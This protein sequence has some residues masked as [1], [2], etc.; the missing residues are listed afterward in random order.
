M[1]VVGLEFATRL[2]MVG[3]GPLLLLTGRLGAA[4]DQLL[5][6]EVPAVRLRLCC[7]WRSLRLRRPLTL[8]QKGLGPIERVVGGFCCLPLE[9]IAAVAAVLTVEAEVI[10]LAVACSSIEPYTSL[11]SYGGVPQRI[12]L[13]N[14]TSTYCIMRLQVHVV[15]PKTRHNR[16]ASITFH[17]Q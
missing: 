1:G 8:R 9:G 10:L 3:T 4:C 14:N 7:R 13:Q 12:E 2:G 17:E 11:N 5:E 15:F 6:S 16:Y